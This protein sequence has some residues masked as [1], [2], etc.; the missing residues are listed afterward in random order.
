MHNRLNASSE[1]RLSCETRPIAGSLTRLYLRFGS[2]GGRRLFS[3]T[4][5][6]NPDYDG[7]TTGFLSGIPPLRI[8]I[9]SV[10]TQGVPDKRKHRPHSLY[11]RHRR[12]YRTPAFLQWS[13]TDFRSKHGAP[14][15]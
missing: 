12:N 14:W 4:W 2:R 11:C 6:T 15:K 7:P 9:V 5:Q 3:V 13:Q 8:D 10:Q 1:I